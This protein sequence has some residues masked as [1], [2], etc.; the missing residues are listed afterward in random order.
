[1]KQVWHNAE[2][3]MYM[4]S[5]VLDGDRLYGL[6]AKKKGQFFCLDARTGAVQWTSRG[7]DAQSASVIQAGGFLL[8]TTTDGE[9]VVTRKS[10]GSFEPVAR[11]VVADSPVWSHAV[12][13]GREILI[14]DA[15][16]LT[17]YALQ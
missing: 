14:K 17:M 16:A 5:P 12:V 9:I 6:S 4:S 11:Y 10:A 2:I 1:M 7:R 13:L 15:S 8:W 3:A